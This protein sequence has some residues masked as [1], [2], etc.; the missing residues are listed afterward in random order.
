L[1]TVGTLQTAAHL[2]SR[3]TPFQFPAGEDLGELRAAGAPDGGAVASCDCTSGLAGGL[4]KTHGMLG[5]LDKTLLSALVIFL[6][7]GHRHAPCEGHT[8]M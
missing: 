2:G 6:L 1:P 4:K 3:A 5:P 8:W 7:L